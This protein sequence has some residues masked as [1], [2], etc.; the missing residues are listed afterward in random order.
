[1]DRYLRENPYSAQPGNE[2]QLSVDLN[3]EEEVDFFDCEY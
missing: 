2:A 3:R 1:M